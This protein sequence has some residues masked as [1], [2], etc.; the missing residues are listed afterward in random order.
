MKK[1]N[2]FLAI[3]MIGS[4]VFAQNEREF[5]KKPVHEIGI[6]GGFTTGVGLSYRYWP[7]KVGIQ[8]TFL[9]VVTPSYSFYSIGLTGLYKFREGEYSS[10][11]GY[12]SNSLF[13]TKY[14]YADWEEDFEHLYSIGVGPGFSFGDNTA[15]INVMG[16]YA[17]YYADGDIALLPTVEA[18]IYYR[19]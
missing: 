11:F 16:G 3:M 9:P 17:L 15:K 2:L 1:M 13:L 18:G 10:F 7:Q 6:A 8:T 5:E 12:L 14:D 4:L 19:F